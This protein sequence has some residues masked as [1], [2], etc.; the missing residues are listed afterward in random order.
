MEPEN[1]IP[2]PPVPTTSNLCEALSLAQGEIQA[3]LKT[4]TVDFVDN[5]GRRVHYKYADLADLIDCL[6][7]PFLKHGLA[8]THQIEP[9]QGG[10]SMIT[11]L[12]HKSGESRTTWYPLPD[13]GSMSPQ[14][15]GSALT[16]ARRY[17]L[18]GLT[19]TAS[20][21]D[22]D[23]K[24]APNATNNPPNGGQKQ[25]PA[26]AGGTDQPP[27]GPL[28][29]PVETPWT[30]IMPKAQLQRLAM[31]AQKM[32]WTK[33]QLRLYYSS[34]WG[35]SSSKQLTVE[36]FNEVLQVTE[37]HPPAEGLARLKTPDPKPEAPQT[38]VDAAWMDFTDAP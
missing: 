33:D 10:I 5:K 29:K 30:G 24:S 2:S 31:S 16:F 38:P 25:K 8:V 35:V 13:P 3:P 4:K 28:P 34:R 21:E 27:K 6:R 11:T 18:S 9:S 14:Q 17:S 22:D 37:A 20:E 32:G 7:A 26:A 15:F 23:G 1:T 19:G 12:W 36:M